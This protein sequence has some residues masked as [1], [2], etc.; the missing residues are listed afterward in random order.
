MFFVDVV[1]MSPNLRLES[2]LGPGGLSVP[3]AE[4]ARRGGGAFCDENAAIRLAT[5]LFTSVSEELAGGSVDLPRPCFNAADA[6]LDVA[7]GLEASARCTAEAADPCD[8]SD[9]PTCAKISG[10]DEKYLFKETEK[11]ECHQILGRVPDFTEQHVIDSDRVQ[12][13]L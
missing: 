1:S 6:N 9:S 12:N 3:V 8:P 10:R 13:S 4:G 7:S 2:R 5:L 11:K